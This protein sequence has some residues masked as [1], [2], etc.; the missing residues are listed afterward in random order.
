MAKMVAAQKRRKKESRWRRHIEEQAR[1]GLSIAGYCRRHG[2][3]ECGFYWW[4]R[5]L[6]RRDAQQPPPRAA[7][8]PVTVAFRE[9]AR[10]KGG[11]EGRLEILL[12]GRRRVRVM[13]AVDKRMLAD[14][15]ALLAVREE[16]VAC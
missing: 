9:P 4:R 1:S 2:L 16:G 13:G 12:P 14:V 7:F 10:I 15:L 6:A 5:E 3:R 8:V 11:G